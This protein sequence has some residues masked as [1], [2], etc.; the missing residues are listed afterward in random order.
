MNLDGTGNVDFG[1]EI[2]VTFYDK[3]GKVVDAKMVDNS[4]D[5]AEFISKIDNQYASILMSLLA[6]SNKAEKVV[7][8]VANSNIKEEAV[9]VRKTSLMISLSS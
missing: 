2:T 6:E 3:N 7:V 1:N 8:S 4:G 9:V 5:E